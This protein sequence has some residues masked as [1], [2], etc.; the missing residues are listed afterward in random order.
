[1]RN[2]KTWLSVRS[3]LKVKC[4]QNEINRRT[5]WIGILLRLQRR[6][7]QRSVDVIVSA[8]FIL[9]LLLLAFLSVEWLKVYPR[10]MTTPAPKTRRHFL[11]QFSFHSGFGAITIPAQFGS[12][13][14]V[15]RTRLL[16]PSIHDVGHQNQSQI[17]Q[18]FGANHRTN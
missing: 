4:S 17:S 1:M 13:D 16:H 10:Q 8:A 12:I 18:Y 7:P 15:L 11:S 6:G 2:I 3:Y 9:T 5:Y 14:L